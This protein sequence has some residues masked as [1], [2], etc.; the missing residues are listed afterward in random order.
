[1]ETFRLVS[2]GNFAQFGWERDGE[3]ERRC[4]LFASQNP[5]GGIFVNEDDADKGEELGAEVFRFR[6]PVSG[7]DVA[8]PAAAGLA[9]IRKKTN[10]EGPLG[11]YVILEPRDFGLGWSPLSQARF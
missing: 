5:R 10:R 6:N 7:I 3:E 11:S 4:V 8:L 9:L 1:M 2:R